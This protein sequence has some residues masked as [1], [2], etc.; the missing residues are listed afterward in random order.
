LAKR[1]I[2]RLLHLSEK[3][4]GIEYK[5][6]ALISHYHR[7]CNSDPEFIVLNY[8]TQLPEAI[9]FFQGIEIIRRKWIQKDWYLLG[10]YC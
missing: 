10:V 3:S 2:G 4:L 9:E 6:I 7:L 1:K 8:K 5:L